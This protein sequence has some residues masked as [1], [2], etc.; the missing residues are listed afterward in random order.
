[1]A[2]GLA[3]MVVLVVRARGCGF[4]CVF[5]LRRNGGPDDGQT[6]EEQH[7]SRKYERSGRG[8]TI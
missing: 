6:G 3:A 4:G 2:G 1:M 8:S 7:W 5:S